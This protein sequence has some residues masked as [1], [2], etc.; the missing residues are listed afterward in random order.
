MI[1]VT[2]NPEQSRYDASVDGAPAG[3]AAYR[4][5]GERVVFTHTEVDDAFGGQGVGSKLAAGALDDVRRQ[6][7]RVVAEC[8]FIAEFIGKHA[9]YADLVESD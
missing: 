5:R 6:G 3:F 9:E 2:D 8:P 7:K 4:L 1:T